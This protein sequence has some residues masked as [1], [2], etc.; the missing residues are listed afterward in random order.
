MKR[1]RS[2]DDRDGSIAAEENVPKAMTT[3]ENGEISCS[4]EET[5][6]VRALLGLKPLKTDKPSSQQAEDNYRERVEKDA[7]VREAEAIRDRVEKAR[8]K[9]LMNASLEGRSIAEQAE[10]ENGASLSAAEWVRRSRVKAVE[11]EREREKRKALEAQRKFDEEDNNNYTSSDLKGLKVMH[12][13][14][15]FESG[16][17]VVLTLADSK[18]LEVD[19]ITGRYKGIN[20]DEDILENVN[21]TEE[22]K[23]LDREKRAKRAARP[24]YSGL[25][26]D[27]FDELQ[28]GEKKS[29]LSHY[30][31]EKKRGPAMMLGAGGSLQD[32][33][34][35]SENLKFDYT[36][37][38]EIVLGRPATAQ[39]LKVE[40]SEGNDF[41]TKAEYASF[42][43]PKKSK[44]KRVSRKKENDVDEKSI[45]AILA[46]E[47]AMAVVPSSDRGSRTGRTGSHT[48]EVTMEEK[49]RVE[50]Y[51]NAVR[52]AA[53][54]N[55][56][57]SSVVEAPSLV[58]EDDDAEIAQSL[59]RARRIAQMKQKL[60]QSEED[61][62]ARHALELVSKVK[63]S[64]QSSS[65][66][67]VMEV[68]EIAKSSA[69][70]VF[71]STTEFTARLQA[72][73]NERAR[74][75]AEQALKT[76]L[77]SSSSSLPVM[78][79]EMSLNS[80][81][82]DEK[83]YINNV[84]MQRNN[85]DD[86]DEDDEW[87]AI[88]RD[89][90]MDVDGNE[91]EDDDDDLEFV[92]RQPLVGSSMAATLALLKGSGELGK[93]QQL[94][95]RSK[96]GE[97][98]PSGVI[99]GDVILEYRDKDGR[100]L[101]QK[102]AYRQLCYKFH[103]YGPSNNKIEKRL[104]AQELKN[105]SYSSKAGADKGTMKDFLSTQE[106][107]GKAYVTIDGGRNI[108]ATAFTAAVNSRKKEAEKVKIK[109][110]KKSQ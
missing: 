33:S 32:T 109:N 52:K 85:D 2:P 15:A 37:S 6:R 18:V 23:R 99:T 12:K 35:R 63:N 34:M 88:D 25:D 90:P 60:E 72:R 73:L 106:A 53:E 4:I 47:A 77:S 49:R 102:E 104:K 67:G 101:T 48:Q 105:K 79:R 30:D 92:H 36:D 65:K 41:Y 14:T 62:G 5:N 40:L 76:A 55:K 82:S 11:N 31:K 107:T 39:S 94:A 26:D 59:A 84:G 3:E 64:L 8:N 103:G 13:T 10:E 61:S 50:D 44:K 24:V 19:E 98:D 110:A 57:S 16:T 46:E 108:N 54:S 89:V 29:I 95:G 87:A 97:Y 58:V 74:D 1:S 91:K 93:A 78:Q 66:D 75:K 80:M 38:S 56:F 21:L 81:N 83:E 17:D 45:E 69:G 27:E 22:D 100:K 71:T 20:E 51:N 7:K 96:D 28:F 86:I 42:A 9:R 70:L 68:E 43:K